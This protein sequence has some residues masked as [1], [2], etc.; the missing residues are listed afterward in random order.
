MHALPDAGHRH[1]AALTPRIDALPGLADAL[2]APSPDLPERL[3]DEHRFIVGNLV[4]HMEQAEATLYPQLERLMQNRHSMTPMRREHDEVRALIRE[5][6]VLIERDLTLGTRL[7]LR[8]VL[9]HLYSILKIHLGE[10]QAYIGVLD[11]NLSDEEQ[12]EL[13]R[14]L[15]HATQA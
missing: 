12:L 8:R 4:P 11:H 1:H 5:M 2:D 9:L 6:G 3:A 10:E 13:A 14:A 7:R 15:E